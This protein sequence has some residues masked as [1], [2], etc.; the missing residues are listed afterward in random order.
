MK[1]VTGQKL[2]KDQE[3]LVNSISSECGILKETARLLFYRNVD[4]VQKA[5]RFIN[6]SKS[7]FHSPYLFKQMQQAVETTLKFI[8]EKKNIII[9]GDY[10]ADGICATAT[11]NFALKELG[12]NPILMIP[13][14]EDGYGLNVEKI[15]SIHKTNPIGLLITVDCGISEKEAIKQL[16]DSGITVIVTDH[17]EPPTALPDCIIINPKKQGETYP[18]D[19]LCGAGV[20][21][22]FATALIGDKAEKYLDLVA[23]AT[24]A[25]SMQLTDENR[26]IVTE[27]LKLFNSD[28]IRPVFKYLIGE[29][30]KQVNAGTLAWVIAPRINAGGRMGDANASLNLFIS[31]DQNQIKTLA[32]QLNEYNALRQTE[33]ERVFEQAVLQIK[34]KELYRNPSICVYGEDWNAGVVGIVASK[35]V[36]AYNL[37]AIVFAE[38]DG[39]L[40][41]SAR[42][43]DSINIYNAIEGA[44]QAVI[45]FGGHAQ[46]AGVAV[47]KQNFDYFYNLLNEYIFSTYGEVQTEKSIYC[48]WEITSPVSL[49]FAREINLLEPF[50]VGNKKPTF[51]TQIDNLLQV[52]PVKENSPHYTF[53]T[54]ALQMLYFNAEDQLEKLNLPIKKKIIFEI[55]HSVFRSVESVKGF[56]KQVIPDYNDVEYLAPYLF[57]NQLVNVAEPLPV[58]STLDYSS[59]ILQKGYG[60]V[61]A[62]SNKDNLKLYDLKGLNTYLFTPEQSA[63]RNCVV[64][65]LK[66]L[67]EEYKKIVFL[68]SPL[69]YPKFNAEYAVVASVNG[70]NYLDK[71]DLSRETFGEIYKYL[72]S[73]TGKTFYN[74]ATFA[75]SNKLPFDIFTTILATEVFLELG[76]FSVDKNMLVQNQ[77]V[78]NALTNS[79][80][81]SKILNIKGV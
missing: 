39:H 18:F 78:K 42:S 30:D 31:Q 9:S 49:D 43:V 10:D 69:S 13:E 68:D 32:K 29:S 59:E 50:G 65:A 48:D 22:K 20:A 81:Y 47:E 37:P 2:N 11:L 7:N 57:R 71:V 28:A 72:C 23:V 21:Y 76:F 74:S 44:K 77:G 14:R 12:V 19:G 55:N 17:H 26:D 67:P 40:K 79:K 75:I 70:C 34:Q 33:C 73:F 60:T 54:R 16:S 56:V 64:V 3:M 15:L 35:I 27:G 51:F 4:T 62:I 24:V 36:E 61:Y 53:Y 52:Y 66:Q 25:D 46:A 6:P 58:Y 8:K 63:G 41:G 38:Q 80:I 5:K 1:I 45:D